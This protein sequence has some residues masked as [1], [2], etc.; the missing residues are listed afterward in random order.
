MNNKDTRQLY[1]NVF[2]EVHASDELLKKVKNISVTKTKKK[3][4]FKIISAVAAC[5]VALIVGTTIISSISGDGNAFVLKAYAAEIGSDSLI[6]IAAISPTGGSTGSVSNGKNKEITMG[7]IS[8]FTVICNGKNIKT[9]K[10]TIKNAVF[11]FPYDSY[12]KDYRNTYP[13]AAALSDKIYDKVVAEQKIM[14]DIENKEQYI[15]YTLNYSDQAELEKYTDSQTF[16]IQIST[17]ISSE[18]DI[19]DEAKDNLKNYISTT[20][21]SEDEYLNSLSDKEYISELMDAFKIVYDEM[22]SKIHI[23]VEI[24]YEDGTTDI[25]TLRLGCERVSE[26]EGIIIGAKVLDNR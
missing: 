8:P 22:Y 26:K 10:Y 4:N 20:S 14:N 18:D 6:K 25:E 15:S 21:E 24:T 7:S 5:L 23:T 13:D 16:P 2:N 9:I 19:S 1:Q 11:L 17:M 12:A 3:F